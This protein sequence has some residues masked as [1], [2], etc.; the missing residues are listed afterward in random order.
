MIGARI[1]ATSAFGNIQPKKNPKEA[2][3]IFKSNIVK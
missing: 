3:D 1:T 2:A